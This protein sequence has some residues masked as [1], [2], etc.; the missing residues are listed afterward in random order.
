MNSSGL[1]LRTNDRAAR[2]SK[3]VQPDSDTYRPDATSRAGYGN[4]RET[5]PIS[6]TMFSKPRKST[7]KKLWMGTPNSLVTV[8]TS[9]GAPSSM[10][11]TSRAEASF[12]SRTGTPLRW[13]IT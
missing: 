6:S 7:M 10:P 12:S 2:P 3:R 1:R 8:S 4:Q 13:I 9:V 5:P 11:P